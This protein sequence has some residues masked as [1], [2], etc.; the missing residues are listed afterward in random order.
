MR[1]VLLVAYYFPPLGGIAS[2]RAAGFASHLAEFGWETT[3]LAPANGAYY[4][5]RSLSVPGAQ[6]IRSASLELSRSGKRLLR[7]GGSDTIPARPNRTGS[8]PRALA[9]RYL[10]FPDAQIGWYPSALLAG[11]RAA[12]VTSFDAILSS[13][14]P[15]TAHL[16][17]RALHRATRIPWA[18][19]F[20]DPWVARMVDDDPLRQRA[21]ALERSIAR[22]ASTV[23]MTS[24]SWSAEHSRAWGREVATIPNGHGGAPARLHPPQDLVVTYLGSYYPAEQELTT[25]W[26]A[27]QR[28]R[29]DNFVVR[30]RIVGEVPSE[31]A[32]EL[33]ARGLSDVTEVTGFVT[34]AEA[35][36][37][38]ASS[39]VLLAAGPKD[40]RPGLRG[41]I[42][43]KLFDY[44]ATGLPI[45]YVSAMP[46]D[47]AALL[48]EHPGCHLIAP[49]DTAGMVAALR[50]SARRRY[51]R[52]LSGLAR[53]DRAGALAEL[54]ESQTVDGGQRTT[55]SGT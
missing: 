10:Y 9:R 13:S 36:R 24:P 54:L 34:Q 29:H 32:G 20:R 7:A 26:D 4:Q 49:G 25:A 40:A 38:L 37:Q 42:A 39:S 48:T 17:A 27:I 23:I 12:Q 53:R 18:A 31:I 2:L 47:A 51:D 46:N 16:I 41:V 22:E 6:V 14:A 19:E 28:L 33:E 50:A 8:L 5:D 55:V 45:I 52:N 21:R 30:V 11:R 43:A 3:V 35:L 1:R 15:V 44:L